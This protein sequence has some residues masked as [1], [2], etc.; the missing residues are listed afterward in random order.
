[1]R[2]SRILGIGGAHVDRR[3]R[4]SGEHVPGAS[5]PGS[6]HEDAGGGTFNALRVAARRG[7]QAA[8]ISVRGG[9]AAGQMVASAA[10]SAGIVDLS[11]VF[12][13]RATPSYTAVLDRDGDVVAALA[14]MELYEIA[15]PK[16]LR[17]SKIREAV[18]WAD[19]VLTDAN[20]P[21][22]ALQRL[23]AAAEG[24]P[25][26]A[27]AISPAK[28]ARLR[29]V[30]S[31]LACLY[32]NRRE[33]A[34]LAGMDTGRSAVELA[35]RLRELGLPSGTI[36]EGS[37][38]VL[39]FDASGMFAMEPPP[40]GRIVDVTGAGDALAGAAMAAAVTGKPLRAGLREGLAA[41]LLA[42]Q[43]ETSVPEFTDTAF[44]Q[45]VALVPEA[46][47]VPQAAE[48]TGE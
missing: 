8:L 16:Q 5:N 10:A 28:A 44:E 36:S 2:Q 6:M 18:A 14:D 45:A 11:A 31:R 33:A 3:G 22:A 12:L 27:I 15:F 7:I 35:A 4:M 24:T 47:D 29:P 1:M 39:A 34:A 25:V 20:L 37:R 21:E 19:C 17:R 13:D 43:S 38:P 32:M 46:R 42:L 9:D 41:A 23:T 48:G 40:P 26:H 30:L